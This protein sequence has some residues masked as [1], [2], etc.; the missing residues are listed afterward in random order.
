MW[1]KWIQRAV[2]VVVMGVIAASCSSDN[3]SSKNASSGSATKDAIVLGTYASTSGPLAAPS[4]NDVPALKAW[5]DDT[6][7]RGGVNGHPIE[8]K[9][10]EDSTDAAEALAGVRRLVEQEGVIAFIGTVTGAS[11]QAVLP[12]LQQKKIPQI[13]GDSGNPAQDGSP[14]FFPIKAGATTGLP[15]AFATGLTF[16]ELNPKAAET[17]NLGV[18]YAAEDP[19]GANATKLLKKYAPK[20]NMKVVYDA[21]V[22]LSAPEYTAELIAAKDAGAD[23]VVIYLGPN[24]IVTFQQ[25]AQQQG[26]DPVV[27]G[28][29]S[30]FKKEYEA[31][32]VE[33]TIAAGLTYPFF[34]PK[35]ADF[36]A[37]LK[38]Y[39]P[40]AQADDLS[41]A[42]WLSGKLFES[43]GAHLPAKPTSADVLNALYKVK[44]ESLGGTVIPITYKA[45]GP[46]K[47]GVCSTQYVF[48]NGTF[49]APLGF[50]TFVCAEPN[51]VTRRKVG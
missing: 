5:A 21:R 28:G 46:Q 49:E 51:G 3:T 48:K 26:W 33:G 10:A 25:N 15:L 44:N 42:V 1:S 9:I 39:Q 30:I 12:Y 2:V 11:A 34:G 35:L 31:D 29:N 14:M 24:N 17:K 47:E 16:T 41:A 40:S 20:M 7:A 45:G 37:A 13:G 6:N 18:L 19:F 43:L 38:K 32:G 50:D 27:D 22:S 23:A 8:L 4:A 36:R